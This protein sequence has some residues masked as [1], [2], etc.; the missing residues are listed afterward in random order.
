MIREVT[1]ASSSSAWPVAIATLIIG[2]LAFVGAAVG[3]GQK[4]RADR[5]EHWWARTQWGLEQLS[6]G[7]DART[8]GLVLLARQLDSH[9]AT[10]ED[11]EMLQQVGELV[12]EEL[13]EERA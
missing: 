9:L 5:R 7:E 10:R 4:W 3:V 13:R 1:A 11:A 6:F 2:V 12:L 8:I